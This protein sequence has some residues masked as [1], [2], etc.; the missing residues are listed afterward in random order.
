MSTVLRNALVMCGLWIG[1]GGATAGGLEYTPLASA[2]PQPGP[3]RAWDTE[4]LGSFI[5]GVM[6]AQLERSNSPGAVV[7]LVKLNREH[8]QA[9]ASPAV[10]L[11]GYGVADRDIGVP[12]DPDT[13]LFRLGSISKL[14]TATAVMQL[15]EQGQLDLSGDVNE[16]LDDGKIP[17]RYPQPVTL[18]NLLTHTAG[19]EAN[20]YGHSAARHWFRLPD[21][22]QTVA[23]HA[24]AQVQP[25]VVDFGRGDGA[26]YTNFAAT[27]AGHI[28]SRRTGLSFEDYVEQRI[29]A[30]LNME[31]SSFRE[32]LPLRIRPHMSQGHVDSPEDDGE[33]VA[34]GF[35][36]YSPIRP[37]VSASAT[38]ADMTHFMIAHLQ[39]GRFGDQRVL[40][41]NT[42]RLMQ[43]RVL[44]PHP[45][46]D[47]AGLGF[48]EKHLNGRRA[49]WHQGATTQFYSELYLLPDEGVGLFVAYN[50]HP[51]SQFMGS[52]MQRFMDRYFPAVLPD[53]DPAPGAAAS[54]ARYAGTYALTVRSHTTWEKR[55]VIEAA[56]DVQAMP[57]GLR[58]PDASGA[59]ADWIELGEASG[60]FRRE[61]RQDTVAFSEGADGSLYLLGDMAFA[62]R[63]RLA[64][65]ETPQ[66]DRL[67]VRS[68]VAAFALVIAWAAVAAFRHEP[69]GYRSARLL[70]LLVAVV[71]LAIL[72]GV[73][74]SSNWDTYD[75]LVALPWPLTA[76]MALS[77]I[78][79]PLTFVLIGVVAHGWWRADWTRGARLGHTILAFPAGACLWWLYHWNLIGFRV[80]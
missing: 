74:L 28:V 56:I 24:P 45:N 72:G 51:P 68:C 26:L 15:V 41:E 14:F 36:Y 71:D 77:L 34:P 42:A 7:A 30:P 37:A 35:E 25:P 62:P 9:N 8:R 79:T 1:V 57:W 59:L 52:L 21:M 6:A 80:A 43:S 12:V 31:H 11:R 39:F 49:I 44:S 3:T 54:A 53:L 63:V 70:S 55:G 18:K 23:R 16:Y 4:E 20:N 5:D 75:A 61:D 22:A 64:L 10:L 29:F 38:A 19:F 67:F 69:P 58:M 73:Q 47:G 66:F 32:P 76:A 60:V 50:G 46:V 40:E 48:M 27:L 13:T 78:A 33:L 65:I 17:A 2:S